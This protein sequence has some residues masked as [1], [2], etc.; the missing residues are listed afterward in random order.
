M[1]KQTL[2]LSIAAVGLL[3][4]AQAS[5]YQHYNS[6]V[7]SVQTGHS[8]H[9][10]AQSKKRYSKKAARIINKEQ[11]EQ[12]VMIQQGIKTCQITPREAV[13]LNVQQSKINKLERRL[14]SN[15]LSKW[16]FS[17]LNSSLHSARVQINAFT[18]NRD[19]CGRGYGKSYNDKRH[20]NKYNNYSRYHKGHR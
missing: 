14:S 5:A 15:G 16:E 11:H 19:T 4:T 6:Y 2:I 7:L 3:L 20:D 8:D 12:A 10:Q 1:I 18:K 13:T 9:S 17:K